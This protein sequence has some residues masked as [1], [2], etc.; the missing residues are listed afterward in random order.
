LKVVA[1]GV[2]TQAQLAFLR[3]RRCDEYQG[4]LTSKAVDAD[5][6]TKLV[7]EHDEA[8]TKRLAA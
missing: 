4:W 7:A 1:E 8:D 5:A 3:S 6:F 2:E